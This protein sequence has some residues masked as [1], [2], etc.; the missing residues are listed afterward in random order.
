MGDKLEW[1]F[2]YRV[3][4]AKQRELQIPLTRSEQQR[5]AELKQ[6]LPTYVPTLDE[7]DAQTLLHTALAAQ[8]VAGGRFGSG[9]LRNVSAVGL[10]I[11]TAEEPPALGQ[12]LIV[13]VSEAEHGIEYTFPC[14][15]IARVVRN[16]ASMGVVFDGVPSQT[17]ALGKTSG[18]FRSEADAEFQDEATTK[19]SR[20]Y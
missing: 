19:V 7:R 14:R 17:R 18:V 9:V 10:A 2:E 4:H 1:V 16:P 15:V 20:L 6:Q 11:E 3:L 5:A 13:H 8:F 12:R